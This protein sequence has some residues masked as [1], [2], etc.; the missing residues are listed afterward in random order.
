MVAI[1][2]AGQ[3]LPF[4]VQP[5]AVELPELQGEPEDIAAEKCRLAAAQLGGAGEVT[6]PALLVLA[7]LC[8]GRRWFVE[9]LA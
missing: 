1:L 2:A 9:G 3:P 7:G 5:A 8:W 6:C 4:T